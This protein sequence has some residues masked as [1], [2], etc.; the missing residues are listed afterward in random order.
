MNSKIN[1]RNQ[2]IK[3]G[4]INFNWSMSLG[5]WKDSTELKYVFI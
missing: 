2:R 3:S 5:K 4:T 1:V